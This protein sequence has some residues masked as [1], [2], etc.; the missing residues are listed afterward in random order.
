ML[1]PVI[2]V[3]AKARLDNPAHQF[4]R[5][6]DVQRPVAVVGEQIGDVY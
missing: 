4:L 2:G 6:I 1:V 3:V 5:V